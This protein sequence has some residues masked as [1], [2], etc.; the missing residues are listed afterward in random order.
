MVP[1][2]VV[3]QTI[4]NCD[5]K[6]VTP[7]TLPPMAVPTTTSVPSPDMNMRNSVQLSPTLASADVMVCSHH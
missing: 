6:E 7:M 2:S 4:A 3:M 1:L 5:K